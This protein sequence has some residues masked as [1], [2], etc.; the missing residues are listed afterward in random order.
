[1]KQQIEDSHRGKAVDKKKNIKTPQQE[2]EDSLYRVRGK[3]NVYGIPASGIKNC[4]VTAAIRYVEGI[5]GTV[6]V[7]AFHII[8]DIDG[9]CPIKG[10]KPEIDERTV[11]VGNFPNKK[12]C[13]RRRAKF[14]NWECTFT[15]KYNASV[16]TPDQLVYL[17]ENAGFSVGLCEYRPEKNGNMGMFHVKRA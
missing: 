6:A 2:F 10:D 13:T 17:Y 5:T 16:I 9:L 8:D 7:G 4:A 1:M 12:P 3:K 15:V 14:I 11:R